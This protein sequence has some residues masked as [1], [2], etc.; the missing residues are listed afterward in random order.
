[1]SLAV[2]FGGLGCQMGI[3]YYYFKQNFA[4]CCFYCLLL[5]YFVEILAEPKVEKNALSLGMLTF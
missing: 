5:N 4:S 2:E 1:M 3:Y